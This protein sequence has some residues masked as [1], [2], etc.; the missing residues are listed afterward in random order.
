MNHL[1]IVPT[2]K[3]LNRWDLRSLEGLTPK[4]L[5][6]IRSMEWSGYT[7]VRI[8]LSGS[9]LMIDLEKTLA[10]IG[11]DDE[12]LGM[13]EEFRQHIISKSGEVSKGIRKFKWKRELPNP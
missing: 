12:V 11:P 8:R 3:K 7:P 4:Q 1:L 2:N 9:D 13:S 10:L 5:D 6:Y